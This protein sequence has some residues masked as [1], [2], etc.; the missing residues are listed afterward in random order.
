MALIA[1]GLHG[2]PFH[3]PFHE[4][5]A[6]AAGATGLPIA[7]GYFQVSSDVPVNRQLCGLTENDRLLPSVLTRCMVPLRKAQIVPACSSR[8]RWRT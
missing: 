8:S 7:A 5:P 1:L 3:D 6:A 2:E 4:Q